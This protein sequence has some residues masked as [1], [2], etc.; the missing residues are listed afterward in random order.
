[1]PV[2]KGARCASATITGLT[3]TV[4]A[5]STLKRSGKWPSEF[6]RGIRSATPLFL[7]GYEDVLD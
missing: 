2:K 5:G 3:L 7:V 4:D 1:M 6:C